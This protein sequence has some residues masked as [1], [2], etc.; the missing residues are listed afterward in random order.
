MLSTHV[1]IIGAGPAGSMTALRLAQDKIPF[2]VIDKDEFPREKICG[3]GLSGK[4]PHIIKRLSPE[5][6]QRFED[7]CKPLHS[8]GM[9]F[10]APGDFTFDV[11]FIKDY[12]PEIHP[13][14]GYTIKREKLDAFMVEEVIASGGGKVMTGCSVK[15]VVKSED[16][17]I[18]YTESETIKTKLLIDAS[19]ASSKFESP[20]PKPEISHKKTALAVRAYYKGVTGMH[21]QNFIELYFLKD[22]LPG[23]FWIFPLPEGN[24]NIGIG[25]RKDVVLKKKIKLSVE[26]D[27]IIKHHPLVAPRFK[28]AEPLGKPA[29]YPLPL[30]KP[31]FRISGD[32]Y[33]LAGDAGHLIDP[34][35][36]EGIGNALYSGYIAAEQAIA[37]FKENRFDATF[38]QAYDKRINRVLGKEMGISA[39][40]QKMLHY[41]GIVR[42]IAKSADGNV[43]VPTL[44]SSMFTNM[45]YRKKL[46]NPFF[47]LKI[48]MNWK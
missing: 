16:G 2:V 37:C 29:A 40:L 46:Y 17:F 30:G 38:M 26:M 15:S 35:T 1:C 9:R 21:P 44:L 22:I 39:N 12:D 42:R 19:G 36:G 34:L 18:I 31:K 25:I 20:I 11:P 28:N 5:L 47:L 32:A 4:V 41:P 14:P 7:K 23:Y 33:M 3:D 8:F 6:L 24:A 27:K 10:V 13:V 43:H 48:L 45:D